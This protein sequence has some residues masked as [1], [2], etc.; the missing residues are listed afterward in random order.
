MFKFRKQR[1]RLLWIQIILLFC[2]QLLE[3]R[4][5]FMW[6]SYL[7]Y[8]LYNV[9]NAQ[10]TD[11][12]QTVVP[13]RLDSFQTLI[14]LHDQIRTLFNVLLTRFFPDCRPFLLHRSLPLR[15]ENRANPKPMLWAT[16][17]CAHCPNQK[18]SLWTRWVHNA[19]RTPTSSHRFAH[20]K[21]PL[22][23]Q[24]EFDLTFG[25]DRPFFIP[26]WLLFRSRNNT[27]KF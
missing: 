21:P 3:S 10:L 8:I 23:T 24:P 6:N 19:L 27:I 16:T 1:G 2:S 15:L 22:F 18:W 5:M 7:S 12:L 14:E 11:I 26:K 17:K 9:F 20:F 13:F 25:V 4:N